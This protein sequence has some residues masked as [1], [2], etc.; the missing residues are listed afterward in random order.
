M[1]AET[2]ELLR[3]YA[4][5]QDRLAPPVSVAEA[6]ARVR[7]PALPADGPARAPAQLDASRG[8]RGYLP[9]PE[10]HPTAF[11]GP[12][13]RRSRV[14]VV[15]AV[16]ALLAAT[17]V[18]VTRST[19]SHPHPTLPSSTPRGGLYITD[20][21]AV[22]HVNLDGTGGQQLVGG[23]TATCGIAVDRD[24][25]YWV[26]DAAGKVGRAKRDGTG[27]N[28]AF[29]P[30]DGF[31]ACGVAVDTAHIYWA[32]VEAQA[33]F[34]GSTIGRANLD[35][36]G[37]TQHFITAARAPCGVAVDGAHI[38]WANYSGGTIGRANLDGTGVNENFVTGLASPCSVGVDSSHIYWGDLDTSAIGRADID[39][40]NVNHNFITGGDGPT[41]FAVDGS[42][43]YW[44]NSGLTSSVISLARGLGIT[45]ALLSPP[46]LTGTTIG[47]ARLDGTDVRQNFITGLSHPS[48]VAIGLT[49][50][51]TSTAPVLSAT[52]TIIPSTGLTDHQ[53][54]H[55]VGK[56]YVP[57]VAYTATECANEGTAV[58]A[59]SGCDADLSSPATA[60]PTGAIS[61]YLTVAACPATPGCVIRVTNAGYVPVPNI[62]QA[63]ETISFR[64]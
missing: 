11:D 50:A 40:T 16:A 60:D 55:V 14:I 41:G 21:F 6:L 20:Q 19:T 5:Q 26:N 18:V 25:I 35:G 22:R 33:G 28:P 23:L 46:G 9:E 17:V 61:T 39:G 15:L 62:E 48:G 63:R 13:R 37:V 64:P 49:G 57:G 4:E 27:V 8:E 47:R 31:G 34:A 59:L 53:V 44:A 2:E 45:N 29:V 1:S 56:G 54:V 43:L 38:Y 32:N 12:R 30:D 51:S 3:R 52:V 10:G 24:Y 42:Y 58:L 36:T 7:L